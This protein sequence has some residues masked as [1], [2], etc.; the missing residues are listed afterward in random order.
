VSGA[1]G[2]VSLVCDTVQ[3]VAAGQAAYVNKAGS[4]FSVSGAG[5]VGFTP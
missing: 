5:N 1:G 3:S 4:G 2:G